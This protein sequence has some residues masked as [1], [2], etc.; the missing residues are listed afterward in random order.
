MDSNGSDYSCRA[1]ELKAEL[2]A[3]SQEQI[4]ITRDLQ[5]Q[6]AEIQRIRS[7]LNKLQKQ[8]EEAEEKTKL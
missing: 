4:R 1:Q 3:V 5:E 8:L 6:L 2:G 7:E